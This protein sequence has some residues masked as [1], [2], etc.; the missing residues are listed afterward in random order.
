[1]GDSSDKT[2]GSAGGTVQADD[3]STPLRD[4]TDRQE[5]EE[6]PIYDQPR[7]EARITSR[8][9]PW[10]YIIL[11][12]IVIAALAWLAFAWWF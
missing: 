9:M 10:L 8:F 7:P 1:V 12:I 2:R 11:A 6:G 4:P 3:T 5:Q